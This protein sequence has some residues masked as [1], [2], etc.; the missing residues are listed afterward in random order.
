MKLSPLNVSGASG[1]NFPNI[2]F[3]SLIESFVWSVLFIVNAPDLNP[4]AGVPIT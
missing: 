1:T 3:N 2:K 4:P